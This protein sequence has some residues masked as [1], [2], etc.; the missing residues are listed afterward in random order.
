MAYN[1]AD[2]FSEENRID[3]NGFYKEINFDEIDYECLSRNGNK[4]VHILFEENTL[5]SMLKHLCK[6]Q[7]KLI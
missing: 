3:N 1:N 2:L 4:K 6:Q 7:L 5:P